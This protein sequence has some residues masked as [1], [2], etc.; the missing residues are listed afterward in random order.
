MRREEGV[1]RGAGSPGAADPATVSG[2]EC[3]KLR[4]SLTHG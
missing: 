1:R 2:D 3:N 4:P